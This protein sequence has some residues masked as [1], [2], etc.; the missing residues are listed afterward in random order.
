[1][2]ASCQPEVV[3]MQD[4]KSFLAVCLIFRSRLALNMKCVSARVANDLQ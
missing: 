2:A 1:M 3:Q 4:T